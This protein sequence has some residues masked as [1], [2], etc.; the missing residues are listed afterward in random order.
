M[1]GVPLSIYQGGGIW[2]GTKAY[3]FGGIQ[4]YGGTVQDDILQYTAEPDA[5]TTLTLSLLP[6][7]IH[8]VWTPPPSNSYAGSLSSYVLERSWSGGSDSRTLSTST[9]TVT[10]DCTVGVIYTYTAKAVGTYGTSPGK[11]SA[12]TCAGI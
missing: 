3:V 6:S 11:S 8:A 4:F 9:L 10:D 12:A 7:K 2:T 1:Y 5:P